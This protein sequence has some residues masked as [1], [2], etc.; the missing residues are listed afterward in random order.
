MNVILLKPMQIQMPHCVKIESKNQA[1]YLTFAKAHHSP[2]SD[3]MMV[4]IGLCTLE[5]SMASPCHL[6]VKLSAMVVFV[7]F[8]PP[9]SLTVG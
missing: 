7:G 9:Y 6:D 2:S 5:V 3:G 4:I 1:S 8:M